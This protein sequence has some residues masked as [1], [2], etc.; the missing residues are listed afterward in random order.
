VSI[1]ALKTLKEVSGE[2]IPDSNTLVP[3]P[4]C[5]EL[6]IWGND[7]RS[8]TSFNTK[9]KNIL[10]SLNIPETNGFIITP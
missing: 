3:T 7:N 9:S 4:G 5:D 6:G 1:R 2:S 10:A 8:N